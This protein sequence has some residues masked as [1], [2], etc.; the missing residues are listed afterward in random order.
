MGHSQIGIPAQPVRLSSIGTVC[1]KMSNNSMGS[2][3]GLR[4]LVGKI[5]FSILRRLFGILRRLN[6]LARKILALRQFKLDGL[7]GRRGLRGLIE[8]VIRS[9]LPRNPVSFDE[10]S[11]Q[12]KELFAGLFAELGDALEDLYELSGTKLELGTR[13]IE[14]SIQPQILSTPLDPK[15]HPAQRRLICQGATNLDSTRVITLKPWKFSAHLRDRP[16]IQLFSSSMA[17]C[18]SYGSGSGDRQVLSRPRS[19]RQKITGALNGFMAQL[20][21][22]AGNL[23]DS[24]RSSRVL[25]VLH[26][27][28]LRCSMKN[29]Y[30]MYSTCVTLQNANLIHSKFFRY[31]LSSFTPFELCQCGVPNPTWF[32]EI[33]HG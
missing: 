30:D 32:H 4:S 8:R 10:L 5:I 2:V 18:L 12:Y 14:R 13:K 29:Q 23:A 3:N 26:T 17:S 1:P 21:P 19:H 7:N 24:C 11:R 9:S 27:W 16:V 6:I 31:S 20:E 33:R 22:F 25:N 15:D 28:D